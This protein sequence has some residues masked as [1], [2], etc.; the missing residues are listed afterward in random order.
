MRKAN[1]F[2]HHW[3]P[4]PS[5]EETQEGQ[6]LRSCGWGDGAK[7]GQTSWKSKCLSKVSGGDWVLTDRRDR[8]RHQSGRISYAKPRRGTFQGLFGN[9]EHLCLPGMHSKSQDIEGT[10]AN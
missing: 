2:T 1:I 6:T 4:R 10:I 8:E 5:E 7:N 3:D 9:I